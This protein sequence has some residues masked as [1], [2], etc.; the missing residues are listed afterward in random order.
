[1][2]L[3][4]GY[5]FLIDQ[6]HALIVPWIADTLNAPDPALA[7]TS[8]ALFDRLMRLHPAPIQVK[9]LGQFTLQIGPNPITKESLRLRRAGELLALLLSSPGHS[10]SAEAVAEAMCPEKDPCAAFELSIQN[11]DW[12]Q[13]IGTY[14]GEYLPMYCYSEWALALREHYSDLYEKSLIAHA[15]NALAAGDPVVC[16]EIARWAL[17][18]NP[19]QEQAVQLGMRAALEMGDRVAAIKLYQR[20]EKKL[21]KELGIAQQKELQAL[22]RIILKRPRDP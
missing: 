7:N 14:A 22:Y 17:L 6:E 10:L 1:M 12:E 20:L 11:K 19:W 15:A 18:Q 13:A 21:G 16:L 4:N 2:I 9:T 5:D 3:E 8:T